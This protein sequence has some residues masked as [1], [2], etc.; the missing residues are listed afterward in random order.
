MSPT[1][2][3]LNASVARGDTITYRYIRST[4]CGCTGPRSRLRVFADLTAVGASS[5]LSVV[6]LTG[7]PAAQCTAPGCVAMTPRATSGLKSAYESPLLGDPGGSTDPAMA[8]FWVNT[9]HFECQG[10]RKFSGKG[11]AR[12][13]GNSALVSKGG[14]KARARYA[15]AAGQGL[16]SVPMISQKNCS[17]RLLKLFFI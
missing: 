7:T 11:F 15:G 9:N 10:A 2:H 8:H 16:V 17:Y 12:Y 6:C 4:R 5:E 13:T 1:T 3:S 14:G